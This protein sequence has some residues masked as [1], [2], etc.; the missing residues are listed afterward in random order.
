MSEAWKA[1]FPD[2]GETLDDAR[3]LRPPSW[4]SINDAEDAATFAC[5]L[6]YG[7]RDGWE[8]NM[9][10]SFPIVIVAPDGTETRWKA[11]NEAS[12]NHCA[13]P[14]DEE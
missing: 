10:S 13:E 12:V 6:D 2:D 8:R 5:E 3:E 11:W 1:Y 14:E 7:G 9:E 4:K